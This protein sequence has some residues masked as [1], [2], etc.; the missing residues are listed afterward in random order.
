MRAGASLEDLWRWL[1]VVRRQETLLRLG[2]NALWAIVFAIVVYVLID[3]ASR[4]SAL[5]ALTGSSALQLGVVAFGAGL[6]CGLVQALRASPNVAQLARRLDAQLGLDAKM[7]TS[8]QVHSRSESTRDLRIVEVALLTDAARHVDDARA[9]PLVRT[10][11]GVPAVLVALL[12]PVALGVSVLRPS[13]PVTPSSTSVASLEREQDASAAEIVRLAALMERE[14]EIQNDMYMRAVA[15]SLRELG[16]AMEAPDHDRLA[17]EQ[18]LGRLLGHAARALLGA[19]SGDPAT[20][21]RLSE[22]PR[23]G[24]SPAASRAGAED[25]RSPEAQEG[26]D[27]ADASTALAE[28]SSPDAASA[29]RTLARE[30]ERRERERQ[31]AAVEAR[32]GSVQATAPPPQEG[33][34]TPSPEAGPPSRRAQEGAAL[35]MSARDAGEAIDPAARARMDAEREFLERRR[36]AGM[37]QPAARAPAQEAS[38]GPS[39]LAGGGS[40]TQAGAE[41]G[42]PSPPAATE[43]VE[44]PSDGAAGGRRIEVVVQPNPGLVEASAPSP[45]A[46]AAWRSQVEVPVSR[47]NVSASSR[48]LVSDYFL[49]LQGEDDEVLP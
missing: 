39:S 21:A 27:G 14:A 46:R 7:S 30:L 40:R 4:V 8:W 22:G 49:R 13:P 48:A 1:H 23:R 43:R 24:S 17:T 12:L 29:V 6:G 41:E 9:T 18:E 25:S 35:N 5:A 11:M 33:G 38:P 44:L 31:A 15:R 34:G 28:G 16:S 42:A 45:S 2:T 32:S 10:S 37:E 3:L 19:S 47:T 20:A 26:A 36:A